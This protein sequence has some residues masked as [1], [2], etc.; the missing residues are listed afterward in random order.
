MKYSFFLFFLIPL[1]STAQKPKQKGNR[2]PDIPL[3]VYEQY[4][5]ANQERHL[6]EY[7]ELVSIPAISSA[8]S[9]AADVKTAANWIVSK[10][11]SI[12]LENLQLFPTE[13]SPIIYGSW[14]KAPGKPTVLVYAH[15]DVQ[16]VKESEWRIPPFAAKVEDG[17]IYGRGASDDKSGIMIT[18][19]TA[20]AMLAVDGKLPVNLKFMFDGEEEI[21]SPHFG[22]F[23]QQNK[24]L[25]KADF[26]VNADGDQPN[27]STG[28]MVM[29]LRG[30]A[31]LE[32]IIKTADMDAHSGQFGGKTPNA[33]V[34]MAQVIA[35][36]YDEKGNVA[37]KG[38]Y[39]KVAP[40]TADE[41]ALLA[42]VPYDKNDDM[43]LLGTTAE[44]GDTS[45]S[46]LERIWYRPTLEIVGMQS[47]Y[48]AAEG[49]SNIIP[50]AA[51]ARITCRLVSNQTGKE[52]IDQIV[53]HINSHLPSGAS[54]IFHYRTGYAVPMKFPADN[55][56]FD[57]VARTLEK[58]YGK[59]PIQLATG[60]TVG[61]LI[62]IKQQL[63][64]YAYSLAFQQPDERWHSDNEFFRVSSLRKGQL[65]YCYYLKLLAHGADKK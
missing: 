47:G 43:K 8:P 9:H 33:A 17:K 36:F 58:I 48:T 10:M 59:P 27:D 46:P 34:A 6:R 23:L 45:F 7:T 55:A 56:A 30:A 62:D 32:F 26:A 22:S 57:Y 65:A 25:L 1:L 24:D 53:A 31:T 41:K 18:L 19:L 37:V 63:G 4:F 50:A 60:G 2:L 64:L 5:N 21:G 44:V 39:D 16:P 40:L 61:P 54:A 14:E 51:M 49:H 42:K 3:H 15:Y 29:A 35:S 11:K 12:G 13:G 28:S 52:I 20:E 38:F